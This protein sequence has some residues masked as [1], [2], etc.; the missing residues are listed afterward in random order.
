MLCS[1][2]PNFSI[3]NL[4]NRLQFSTFLSRRQIEGGIIRKLTRYATITVFGWRKLSGKDSL[5]P[6]FQSAGIYNINF[7]DGQPRANG[8]L[9]TENSID[10]HLPQPDADQWS[11]PSRYSVRRLR[12][13]GI[14]SRHAGSREPSTSPEVARCD[15]AVE[16]APS[17]LLRGWL[18]S[19]IPCAVFDEL[20]RLAA[21]FSSRG[22]RHSGAGREIR[23]RARAGVT[24]RAVLVR[25]E[26]LRGWMY[27][28][29]EKL[30]KVEIARLVV[31]NFYCWL[32]LR[33]HFI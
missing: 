12:I 21:S 3:P 6:G 20:M 17:M 28:E 10:S 25:G 26:W 29:F 11:P 19:W 5:W 32:I 7:R 27:E 2:Q 22:G 15:G 14:P 23:F 9:M 1:I 4:T 18:R 33:R 30:W 13:L 31:S 24:A 16:F 8:T